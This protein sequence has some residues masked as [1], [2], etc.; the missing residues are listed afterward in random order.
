MLVIAK[1]RKVGGSLV[2]TI[3]KDAVKELGLKENEP[4]EMDVKKQRRSF[5][6]IYKG[7]GEFTEA[8]RFDKI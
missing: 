4:I 7:V 5:F 2:A 3:P 1:I 8:D 6:G